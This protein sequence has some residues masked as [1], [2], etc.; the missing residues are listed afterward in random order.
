MYELFGGEE[1]GEMVEGA[2]V[3][4]PLW[5]KAFKACVSFLLRWW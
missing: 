5:W 2:V 1:V 4:A 3:R